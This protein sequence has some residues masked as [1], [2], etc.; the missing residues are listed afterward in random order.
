M[1]AINTI[2][3]IDHNRKFVSTS[4]DRKIFV[5]EYGIPVVVKHLAEPDMQSVSK[6]TV[7]A[8]Y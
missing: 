7:S 3:F 4:E 6:T 5:W 1:G 2:T 8:N